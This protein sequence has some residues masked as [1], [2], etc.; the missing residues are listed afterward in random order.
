MKE[1]RIDRVEIK[2]CEEFVLPGDD[3]YV[4]AVHASGESGWYGPVSGAVAALIEARIAPFV[5]G[6]AVADHDGLLA[7]LQGALGA[8]VET[9]ASWAVGAVDCAVWDLH[10]RAERCPVTALID[11]ASRCSSVPAY[12]SWL[13]LDPDADAGLDAVRR[14]ASQGWP[15]T[16]WSL[17]ADTR[18]DT[19]AN[20]ERLASL[21]R[22]VTD[23]IGAPAAFDALW[24]WDGALAA[25]FGETV[26]PAGLIWLEEPLATG[27]AWAYSILARSRTP[28]A[29]GE[30]LRLG[31]EPAPLLAVQA[32][33]ALTLDVVGCSGI[34]AAIRLTRHAIASGTP[35][36][37]HGRSLAPAVHLAAAFPDAIPAVEYQ[38]QWEPRRQRLFTEPIECHAGRVVVPQGPGLGPVPRRR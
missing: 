11:R 7:L 24:T 5:V 18:L 30:R 17:R 10:A 16:K 20:A 26:D 22:R 27:D 21:V 9:V 15:F 13:K 31:D 12:A 28:V 1:L 29:L 8:P 6:N 23:A 34:T 4:V 25:C 14:T 19:G 35:V 32:L 33:N 38:I 3:S 2:D 36:Y 37:P